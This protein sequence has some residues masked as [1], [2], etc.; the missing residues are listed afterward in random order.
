MISCPTAKA[1]FQCQ[2]NGTGFGKVCA[3][4]CT[5]DCSVLFFY[6]K[7]SYV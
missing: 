4:A 1:Q 3:L 7:G 5:I 2:N 6:T